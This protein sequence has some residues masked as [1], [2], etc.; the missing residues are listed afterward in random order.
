M[1]LVPPPTRGWS[2]ERVAGGVQAPGSPAHAG[3]VLNKPHLI[4]IKLWFPRPRGDGP[5]RS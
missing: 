3:M 5:A 1:I 4:V 2:L